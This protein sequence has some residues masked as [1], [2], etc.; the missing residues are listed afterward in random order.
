MKVKQSA[1]DRAALKA[2][3]GNTGLPT[4]FA[5]DG[6]DGV[7]DQGNDSEDDMDIDVDE[8]SRRPK[9]R[10]GT[11]P[12]PKSTRKGTTEYIVFDPAERAAQLRQLEAE[13]L[14]TVDQ[15]LQNPSTFHPTAST[16]ESTTTHTLAD[17]A[18]IQATLRDRANREL[19]HQNLLKE[20]NYHRVEDHHEWDDED[21]E[22]TSLAMVAARLASPH[23]T[24][25]YHATTFDDI[26]LH[27]TP[28]LTPSAAPTFKALSAAVLAATDF[29]NPDTH[30]EAGI[31]IDSDH[32]KRNELR[33]LVVKVRKEQRLW[34]GRDSVMVLALGKLVQVLREVHDFYDCLG[35][36]T[37]SL[38]RLRGLEVW[39]KGKGKGMEVSNVRREESGGQVHEG[40]MDVDGNEGGGGE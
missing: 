13:E 32:S 20:A 35:A 14:A 27:S 8:E 37:L 3:K 7:Y 12:A 4:P 5:S 15:D 24:H 1:R 19:Q 28:G 25:T 17:L 23:P 40:E 36:V 26:S 6:Q 2:T 11:T 34:A 18:H 10:K 30:R 31:S 16:S 21:E 9:T 22:P 33:E 29:T 38:G 39:G